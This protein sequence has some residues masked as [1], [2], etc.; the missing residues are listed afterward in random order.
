MWIV[1][2]LGCATTGCDRVFELGELSDASSVTDDAVPMDAEIDAT[3]LCVVDDFTGGAI[4]EALWTVYDDTPFGS[5]TQTG[6][7]LVITTASATGNHYGL[8]A[9]DVRDLTNDVISVELIQT[10]DA[11]TA[12]EAG[13]SIQV[14]GTTRYQFFVAGPS[15][16]MRQ[17]VGGVND[18]MSIAYS[19][20]FHRFLR[21]R[22]EGD[23]M[24]WETRAM[25]GE[26]ITR[27][28]T[29][30]VVAVT[31][32]HVDLFA[33]TYQQ[34]PMVPGPARFDNLTIDCRP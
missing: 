22:H 31:N 2:A 14:D 9:T 21:F 12:A 1:A 11:S 34:E 29:P 6:G 24:S 4:D 20:A 25:D 17:T 5:V 7:E 3:L 15:L 18:N 16:I 26:W 23:A 28:N 8:V 33:G 19:P 10:P 13:L 30:A 27:R 32:M